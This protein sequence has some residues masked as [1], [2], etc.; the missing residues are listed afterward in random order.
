M[1]RDEENAR[2]K[3]ENPPPPPT[4]G[5][6][7]ISIKDQSGHFLYTQLMASLEDWVSPQYEVVREIKS[8]YRN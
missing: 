5:Q 7:L 4:Q 6:N 2:V 1:A 8:L 3:K